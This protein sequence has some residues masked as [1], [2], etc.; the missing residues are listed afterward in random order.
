MNKYY[1]LSQDQFE[2]LWDQNGKLGQRGGA[3]TK[4]DAQW[5]LPQI[6]EAQKNIKSIL[7]DKTLDPYERRV[8]LRQM[9]DQLRSL[10]DWVKQASSSGESDEVEQSVVEPT[11]REGPPPTA[12]LPSERAFPFER[13]T[14]SQIV[15]K[16]E[17]KSRRSQIPV[18]TNRVGARRQSL[19]PLRKSSVVLNKGT[20]ST[21]PTTPYS[22]IKK[23]RS[24]SVGRTPA[25]ETISPRRTRSKRAP[26]VWH[27]LEK[28]RALN[29]KM[30]RRI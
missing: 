6:N 7:N 11:V 1:V 29:R 9:T 4:F 10:Y 21:G 14:P 19:P 20:K 13:A 26:P 15:L 17:R 27:T 24:R 18:P 12:L 30:S 22:L 28:D 5:R 23:S 3:I 8:R 2:Q 16:R 25:P